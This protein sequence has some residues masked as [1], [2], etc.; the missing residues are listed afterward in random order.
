MPTQTQFFNATPVLASLDIEKSVAFYCGQ[1]GFTKV[2]AEAGVYGIISRGEVALHFW[3]CQDP[4]IAEATS[5]RI[6]V[7]GIESL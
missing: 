1:L 2:Y 7:A 5:C 6:G 4:A 3:A